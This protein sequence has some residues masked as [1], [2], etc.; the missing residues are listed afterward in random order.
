MRPEFAVKYQQQIT[1]PRNEAE[2]ESAL[3]KIALNLGIDP[4]NPNPQVSMI[5]RG[6]NF[7]QIFESIAVIDQMGDALKPGTLHIVENIG[8]EP[9]TLPALERLINDAIAR[10]EDEK[11]LELIR[12][13]N[14]MGLNQYTQRGRKRWGILNLLGETQETVP[15]VIDDNE[16]QRLYDH[17]TQQ[18]IH[19]N[20]IAQQAAYQAA[21]AAAASATR[22]RRT[23]PPPPRPQPTGPAAGPA[24]PNTNP[25]TRPATN[26]AVNTLQE[27]P[28]TGKS[29][30]WI[31]SWNLVDQQWKALIAAGLSEQ[32]TVSATLNRF[33][34]G[35]KIVHEM[36]L[37]PTTS[38][39]ELRA[40]FAYLVPNIWK[41]KK[42]FD[43]FF[44]KCNVT[45]QNVANQ[46]R[47]QAQTISGLD[48][49]SKQV[50][51]PEN[52]RKL[53]NSPSLAEVKLINKVYKQIIASLHEDHINNTQGLSPEMATLL[54]TLQ[55]E[56][57]GCWTQG[58]KRLN[59]TTPKPTP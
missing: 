10:G 14:L 32:T 44:A 57:S 53:T 46:N 45:K 36:I 34:A 31:A 37:N 1:K 39:E 7:G 41:N 43:D 20:F 15:P 59:K 4:T 25:S 13:G 48:K 56:F 18:I 27:E 29:A 16:F 54:K 11:V 19:K 22:S 47:V 51:I 12:V 24:N 9:E 50:F 23:T 38:P 28:L 35:M 55:S 3:D 52:L 8:R 40:V 17:H 21:Q 42:V 58:V 5:Y 2:I 30:E 33:E 49:F 6:T 26:P